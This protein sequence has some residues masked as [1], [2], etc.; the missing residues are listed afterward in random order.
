LLVGP[1]HGSDSGVFKLSDELAIAQSADF[2]PPMISDARAF[3]R[4]AAANSLSDVYAIGARPV[5]ALNLLATPQKEGVTNALVSM[6]CGA[7]ETVTEAG[8]VICGG[9]TID[10]RTLM[11]GL[12]VTGVIH[13]DRILR[14]TA[15]QPGDVLVLTKP[16]G[17]G[18]VVHA[19]N[20]GEATDAE[21]DY[22]ITVMGT[23]SKLPAEA[24]V[25][26]GAHA[27][28]DITGFGLIGHA[29][30]MI[31]LKQAGIV[32]DYRAIPTFARTAELA[33]A[34]NFPAGSKRNA[35]YTDCH[36]EYVDCPD[37]ARLVLNDAQTSGGLLVSLPPDQAERML[38]L[39][40]ERG[41]QLPCA[42][43][44][45]VVDAHPGNLRVV[46]S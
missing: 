32:L 27:S 28:T 8:A 38:A 30:D 42:V 7:A 15:V 14:N 25:E 35:E 3:G 39:L 41:Y 12:S 20:M 10:S 44:G 40:S 29:L 17:S 26:L 4:I 18:V 34:G 46:C 9:H 6:L 13:P 22:C 24:I 2:F 33:L 36:V 37:A 21:L 5:T 19:S 31:S 16:L 45:R 23:L 1:E 43:V 11:F